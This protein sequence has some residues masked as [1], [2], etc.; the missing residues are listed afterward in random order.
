MIDVNKNQALDWDSEIFSDGRER[1]LL[2]EG[3]YLFEVIGFERGRFPGSEKLC[4]SP[5][6]TITLAISEEVGDVCI[7][8]NLILNQAFEH[9][10]AEFFRSI[11]QKKPGERFTPNWNMI[12]GSRGKA[13]VKPRS[14]TTS[15]G[16]ER[17]INDVGRFYDYDPDDFAVEHPQIQDQS[18]QDAYRSG[19]RRAH[20]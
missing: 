10:I 12:V 6:A 20:Q 19:C 3:D 7:R 2:P 18:D 16:E 15:S 11:G 9:K 14:Y 13:H 17:T 4:A 1:L 8:H 5:K